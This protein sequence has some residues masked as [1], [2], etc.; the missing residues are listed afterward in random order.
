MNTPKNLCHKCPHFYEDDGDWGCM[1]FG[2][3]AERCPSLHDDDDLD[4]TEVG[5]DVGKRKLNFLAHL[6]NKK[7]ESWNKKDCLENKR[8]KPYTS[9]EK[10][11]YGYKAY[12]HEECTTAFCMPYYREN[13]KGCHTHNHVYNTLYRSTFHHGPRSVGANK[14]SYRQILLRG[15]ERFGYFVSK[16]KLITKFDIKRRQL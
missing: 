5:C 6:K 8:R 9:K 15:I 10:D 4:I 13:M 1:L 2:L 3:E 11:K 14:P 7:F 16:G 12:F